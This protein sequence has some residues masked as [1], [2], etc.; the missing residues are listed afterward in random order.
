MLI[1]FFVVK[2]VGQLSHE[3]L[4]RRLENSIK[5]SLREEGGCKLG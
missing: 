4:R 1:I 3:T 5:S 2:L